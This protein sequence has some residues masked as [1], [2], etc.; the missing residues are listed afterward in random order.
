MGFPV[1]LFNV[2]FEK[3]KKLVDIMKING[4]KMSNYWIVTFFFQYLFYMVILLVYYLNGK[5]T[6]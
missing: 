1:F 5:F 2:V 4:V 6:F 3:E